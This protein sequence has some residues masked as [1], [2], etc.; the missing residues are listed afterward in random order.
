MPSLRF[1]LTVP[2][3]LVVD[4]GVTK[5][6]IQNER[7]GKGGNRFAVIAE[8]LT[9]GELITMMSGRAR[10]LENRTMGMTFYAPPDSKVFLIARMLYAKEERKKFRTKIFVKNSTPSLSDD[11]NWRPPE[12]GRPLLFFILTAPLPITVDGGVT[13]WE[14]SR[15]PHATDA[16]RI[17]IVARCLDT[18]ETVRFQDGRSHYVDGKCEEMEFSAFPKS[19]AY[20]IALKLMREGRAKRVRGSD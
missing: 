10:E 4:G 15:Q 17:D 3:P 19:K 13:K 2:L 8:C 18:G 14:Q 5:W 20:L 6:R 7:F 16:K 1:R 9:T 12:S 11:S